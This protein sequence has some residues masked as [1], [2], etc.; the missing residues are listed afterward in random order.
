MPELLDPTAYRNWFESPL[1]LRV[2]QP[3]ARAAGVFYPPWTPLAILL[4]PFDRFLGRLTSIG[5]AFIAVA[6][7]KPVTISAAG[8]A[9]A[10]SRKTRRAK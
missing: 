2:W 9:R 1:G 6:G 4:G 3:G 7:R 5:A 10:Q 8:E